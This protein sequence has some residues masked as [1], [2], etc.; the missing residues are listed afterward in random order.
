ME[1]FGALR[2]GNFYDYLVEKYGRPERTRTVAL[3]RVN[4]QKAYKTYVYVGWVVGWNHPEKR[5]ASLPR[6]KFFWTK[7]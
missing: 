5:R 2:R 4:S 3:Y 6:V 1:L 7:T